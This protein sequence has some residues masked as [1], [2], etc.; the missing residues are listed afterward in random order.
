MQDVIDHNEKLSRLRLARSGGVGPISYHQLFQR[1]GSAHASI[2]AILERPQTDQRRRIALAP[3]GAAEREW[4]A[5]E[6]NGGRLITFGEAAYPQALAAIADPPPVLTIKGD[7][8][9]L[10]K[11][12]IAIVGA[13]NAS[14][15]G[16]S[17]AKSL[18]RDLGQEGFVV[19]SGL[20][21]G[22]DGAAHEGALSTGTI[23]VLAGGIDNIY[24]PEHAKLYAEIADR[25]A[26]LSEQPLGMVARARD[27]PKRN[28]IVSGLSLGVVVVEAAERS[29]TLITARLASEQGRD[30]FAVPGSPMDPRCA[31]TNQLLRRGAIL[32]R[33]AEDVVTELSGRRQHL[34]EPSGLGWYADESDDQEPPE[35][36]KH[37]ILALLS[38][39]PTHKD[40]LITEAGAPAASVAMTLLDLVLDGVACETSGGSYTLAE[41][42][43]VSSIDEVFGT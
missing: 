27:F 17:F 41:P 36:L 20:A 11:P 16:R 22:T 12:T 18:A 7:E 34:F 19:A 26:V 2:E 35:D 15:A 23:A 38:Y 1:F 6:K 32:L 30:V 29:G 42:S 5:A 21:R 10:S 43:S 8:Q 28:R 4:A 3:I 37:R 9:L 13:R 14:A 25:G 31:G 40:V 24:P 33:D 39:T